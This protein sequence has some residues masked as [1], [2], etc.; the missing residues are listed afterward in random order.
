M[1]A[2]NAFTSKRGIKDPHIIKYLLCK[3]LGVLPSQIDNEDQLEIRKLLLIM[4]EENKAEIKQRKKA[5]AKGKRSGR[6]K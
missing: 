3:K 4:S 5:F 1:K 6:R 2:K